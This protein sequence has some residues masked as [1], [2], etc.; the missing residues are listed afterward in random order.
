MKRAP[1]LKIGPTIRSRNPSQ[2]AEGEGAKGWTF[3]TNHSHII[4]CLLGDPDM[5][6]RD[7]ALKI[8]IT[9]RAVLRILGELERG[10]VLLVKR[11]GRRN[12][13][14]LNLDSPLRHSLESHC[15]MR[16]LVKFMV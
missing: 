16:Q 4:I 10:D 6:E 13:Y 11:E 8:G 3:L 15:S 7:L 2:S 12:H 5:R 9:E 14:S 1:K